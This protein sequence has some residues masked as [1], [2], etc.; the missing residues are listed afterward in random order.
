MLL[1]L[2]KKYFLLFILSLSYP[3]YQLLGKERE[4]EEPPLIN[5]VVL[6][7]NRA[8]YT[9]RDILIYLLTKRIQQGEAQNY[10]LTPQTWLNF[11]EEFEKDFIIFQTAEEIA[12]Y[13]KEN[14]DTKS[15][16]EFR[17]LLKKTKE[18]KSIA[19]IFKRIRPQLEE[20][21]SSFL[22]YEAIHEQVKIDKQDL[23]DKLP[24]WFSQTRDESQIKY[25]K[26]AREYE[27]IHSV[28]LHKNN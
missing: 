14:N 19:P 22:A 27:A 24:S 16:E 6:S 11:L 15:F 2:Q 20:F 10:K 23:E 25:Y 26:Q 18:D 1:A 8:N 5:R 12:F 13:E 28:Y 21:K 4:T 17:S 3:H 7:I 9:Q